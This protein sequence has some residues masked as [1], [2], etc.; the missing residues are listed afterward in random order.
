MTEPVLSINVMKGNEFMSD[1]A[2]ICFY[3]TG[4]FTAG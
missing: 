4:R 2:E 3:L 1:W